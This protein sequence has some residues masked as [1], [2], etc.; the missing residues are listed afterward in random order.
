MVYK[1][2]FKKS[3]IILLASIANRPHLVCTKLNRVWSLQRTKERLAKTDRAILITSKVMS[4]VAEQ[5]EG[6]RVEYQLYFFLSGVKSRRED[7]ITS[8]LQ[9]TEWSKIM[10]RHQ[11]TISISETKP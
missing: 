7:L 5:W 1:N 4:L 11:S 3:V 6:W 9:S 10:L 2:F 8:A